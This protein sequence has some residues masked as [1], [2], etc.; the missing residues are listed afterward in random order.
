VSE[1]APALRSSDADRERVAVLLRDHCA[2]GRLT[3]EE[4]SDRLS[5]AYAARTGAELDALVADLP[6]RP[7]PPA[8]PPRRWSLAV[9]GDSSVDLRS[10]AL[11]PVSTVTAVA[12]LGDVEVI[13]P[14]GVNVEL[15]GLAVLGDR[16]DRREDVAFVPGAPTVRVRAFALLGDVTVMSEPPR[17]RGLRLPGL[18]PLNR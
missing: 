14:R 18:P 8:A 10:A 13:V 11:P 16:E 7:A 6:E 17:R 4:L 5:S 9:L 3:P 1:D 2:E 12:T 15:A